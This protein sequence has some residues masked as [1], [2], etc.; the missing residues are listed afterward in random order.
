MS[1]SENTKSIVKF[2]NLTNTKGNTKK[3]KPTTNL[4]TKHR[5]R[6]ITAY[7]GNLYNY[8]IK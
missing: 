1:N 6:A 8:K 2:L 4:L 7:G 3:N 5:G